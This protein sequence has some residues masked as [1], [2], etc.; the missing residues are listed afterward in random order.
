MLAS[1]KL[2]ILFLCK[3][4]FNSTLLFNLY[5][6]FILSLL[7]IFLSCLGYFSFYFSSWWGWIKGFPPDWWSPLDLDSWPSIFLPQG[8][9]FISYLFIYFFFLPLLR[10]SLLWWIGCLYSTSDCLTIFHTS[11]I[12]CPQL[13]SVTLQCKNLS[14]QWWFLPLCFPPV[15]PLPSPVFFRLPSAFLEKAGLSPPQGPDGMIFLL[16]RFFFFF[17]QVF[18]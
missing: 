12:I 11:V 16:V 15:E 1:E 9:L 7:G 8:F 4:Y 6:G 2:G 10:W 13:L 17:L 18:P 5:T 3:Q 14:V